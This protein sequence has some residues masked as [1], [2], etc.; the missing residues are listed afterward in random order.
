[1]AIWLLNEEQLLK[2]LIHILLTL[3]IILTKTKMTMNLKTLKN[4]SK[5]GMRNLLYSTTLKLLKYR[6][7]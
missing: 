4:S 2:N 7:L 6:K 3:L 1:M 5:I